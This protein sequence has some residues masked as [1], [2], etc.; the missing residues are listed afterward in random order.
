VAA[1]FLAP[2]ENA[3][4]VSA[5]Q[6]RPADSSHDYFFAEKTLA[7]ALI[8]LIAF[9]LRARDPGHTTA[10]MDESIYV[11][12]GRM[13]LARH[14]EAPLDT[15]LQWSFGWYLW[16]ILSA[17]AARVGGIVA[18]RE[19]S[20]VLGTLSVLAVYGFSRRLFGY[21]VGLGAA[22]LVAVAGPGVMA[23]RIATREAGTVFF[24]SV[25]LWAF[26]RAWQTEE[27]R[28]WL[29]AAT[30]LV[31]AFLCKYIIAIFLPLLFLLSLR[32]GWRAVYAF[33][34]PLAAALG[35]YL[36]YYWPDLRQLLFYGGSYGALRAT[37]DELWRVYVSTRW[38]LWSVAILALPAVFV[39]R[40]RAAALLLWLGA[41][42]ALGFQWKTRADFDFWKHAVYPLIFLAPLA[43]RTILAASR[44]I[45]RS[46]LAQTVLSLG[47]VLL[48]CTGAAWT[49]QSFTYN[50]FV[51]WPN[52]EPVLSYFE[53]RLPGDARVLMDDSVF[54]YYFHPPLSQS[55]MVDPFYFYYKE[56][57]GAA[58]YADAVE[59]GWF[60]YIVFDGGTGAEAKA[61]QQAVRPHLRG[62]TLMLQMPDPVMGQT[63]Q[64]Y[65]R[66]E[67]LAPPA[68]PAGASIEFAT[69][70]N[71]SVVDPRTP[72]TGK[73]YGAGSG[74]YLQPEVFTDRWYPMKR[75]P[76]QAGG[77]F[78][79]EATFA[80]QGQQACHQ[81]L[82]LRL[83][84][85]AG[86]PRAHALLFNL[87]IRDSDCR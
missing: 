55:Q 75:A 63:I 4:D 83:Y 34:L 68:P 82:R 29:L 10:Y 80:G 33:C 22:A 43:V 45:A 84:D 14:F 3:R 57:E 86:N 56:A 41:V 37:G 76:I 24:F 30:A 17:L 54:R 47:G 72:V 79:A 42:V 46:A 48:L 49:G 60:D 58:A 62:Y 7:L 38:E 64:I 23:S 65:Q 40:G 20:A 9:W 25:A 16:P 87:K 66:T 1:L 5:R 85:E 77:E 69:L 51:F 73:V 78:S 11:V 35:G 67:S 70:S 28:S 21:A 81:M 27:R 12:Y 50:R 53:G 8:A 18:V 32:K 31:C 39:R 6:G 2:E 71:S 74:W 13:F 26:V 19:L 52:V 59:D 36:F 44:G 61:M 15:P